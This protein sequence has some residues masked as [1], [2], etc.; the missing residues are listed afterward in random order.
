M[1]TQYAN[2]LINET[3]ST[4]FLGMQISNHLNWKKHIDQILPKLSTAHFSIQRL[5]YIPNIDVLRMVHFAYFH[6]T[7]RYGIII[8]GN[9]TNTSCAFTLQKR[10]IMSGVGAKS[11]C[12]SLFKK[13]HILPV[14]YQYIRRG[15]DKRI[16]L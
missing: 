11:L 9:S 10:I 3:T 6:S 2:K 13:L 4:R 14:S 8:W 7:I 16:Q 5:F 1:A 15:A 12:R